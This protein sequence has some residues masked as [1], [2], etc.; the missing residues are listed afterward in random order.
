M[1]I[2]I[3]GR[4]IKVTEDQ[5]E[6]AERKISKLE[7][8]FNQAVDAHVILYVEKLDHAAEVIVKGDGT[9]FHGREKAKDLFS[10]IDLLLD[11]MEKQIVRYK[12]KRQQ[13]RGA[14]PSEPIKLDIPLHE[15]RDIIINQASSKPMDRI[16]A[17]LEMKQD[18][19][20]F[21]LFKVGISEV[22]AEVDYSN[23]N[24][25]VLYKTSDGIRLVEIPFEA[26]REHHFEC[27]KFIEYDLIVKNDSPA[28]PEIEFR[29]RPECFI[30][31]KTLQEALEETES[32]GD[33]FHI[34][35]NIDSQYFNVIYREGD[36]YEVMVPA[37]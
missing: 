24:Y 36:E 23:K 37:Y 12:E 25:A 20:D 35:F 29:M 21:L 19:F 15:G 26:I 16:E 34:F 3:T 31:K 14:G 27:E 4:N 10:A 8:Y 33:D 6:Y 28:N 13:H 18:N 11:K 30:E 32:R 1:K 2:V 5:K 9:Q 7:N 22:E 17:Y